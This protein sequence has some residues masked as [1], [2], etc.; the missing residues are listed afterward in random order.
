MSNTI[1]QHSHRRK[2]V[3]VTGSTKGLGREIA[4]QVGS[5]GMTVIASERDDGRGQRTA[6]ELQAEGI[7]GQFLQLDVTD[8]YS[9][10][11][12]AEHID[13]EFGCLDVL[14]NNAGI[15]VEEERPSEKRP[16]TDVRPSA[17]TA[18]QVQQ[19]YEVNVFGVVRVTHAM[20]PL[21]RRSPSGRIVNMSSP[22]GSLTFRADPD[23]PI[24]RVGLLAYSSSKAALNAITLLYANELRDTGILV[25]AANPGKVATDINTHTGERTVEQGAKI[26]VHLATLDDDGPTGVFLSD[27]GPVPW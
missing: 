10:Q 15:T 18:D 6:Q 13:E 3:L 14:I 27:N 1:S 19:T 25:N 2:I 17:I 23:H 22:L 9:V 20:L 12:A 26:A 11:R 24:A 8:D 16:S 5:L 21:L 7:D 4:R